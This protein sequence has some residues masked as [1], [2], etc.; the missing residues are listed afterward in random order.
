M[1]NTRKGS[2]IDRITLD[3]DIR[4]YLKVLIKSGD[5]PPVEFKN[6]KSTI[7]L[8]IDLFNRPNVPYINTFFT[9]KNISDYNL[10][11]F[12]MY[13]IFDFDINGLEGFDSNFSGY[14]AE[15][16]IIYQY[17][18]NGLYGG[19]SPIS[20]S[21]HY[22]SCLTKDFKIDNKRLNLSNSLYKGKGEILSALQIEFMTLEP[23]HTFQTALVISGGL[24]RE[25]LIGNIKIGKTNAIK[26]LSQVNRSV[27]SAQRNIQAEAFIKINQQQSV[28]CNDK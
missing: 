22:E 15:N 18:D 2:I 13:F 10:V 26:F 9:M 23:N 6:K 25:E 1:I 21:T 27:K 3:F 20:R 5:L 7:R 8:Y 17:D 24:S 16:D 4:E 14:D 11:D 19:F 12:S 28:N